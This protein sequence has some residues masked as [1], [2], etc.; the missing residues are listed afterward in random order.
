MNY[1]VEKKDIMYIKQECLQ[2]LSCL[3]SIDIVNRSLEILNLQY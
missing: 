1:L 3:V 2:V